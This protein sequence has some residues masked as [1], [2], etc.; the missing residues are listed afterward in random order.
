MLT[1]VVVTWNASRVLEGF[2][3]SLPAGLAGVGDWR[4]VVADNAS[5]DGTADLARRLAADVVPEAL[6]VETG[7]NV[8]YAGGINAALRAAGGDGPVLVTNADLRF[9]PGSV[10]AMLDALGQPGRP[11]APPPAGGVGIVVPRM[12]DG[13]G[14]LI[15]SLRREPTVVRALAEALLGGERAGRLGRLGEVVTDPRP[16][17]RPATPD[18]ASGSVMLLSRACLDAV[19]PW[20]ESF[21]LYSEETDYALRARDAGFAL[22]YEPAAEVTHLEG[23][24]VVAPRLWALLTVNRARLVARRRGAVVG[25]AYRG[26]LLV[27]EALRAPRGGPVH[28][29]ALRALLRPA[30]PTVAAARGA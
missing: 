5:A 16:Y 23:E 21:F 22:R 30:A 9:A 25:L 6:V 2:V 29:A 4:L 10:R 7:W 12:R 26:A 3:A 19:G 18:W 13:D 14:R 8:G 27:R 1:V 11:G 17:E 24:A 20:D 15:P 28:R